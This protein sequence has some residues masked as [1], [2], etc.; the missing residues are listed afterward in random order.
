MSYVGNESSVRGW[1]RLHY[2]KVMVDFLMVD[3]FKECFYQEWANIHKCRNILPDKLSE[4]GALLGAFKFIE[5]TF[6]SSFQTA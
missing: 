4:L 3:W 1:K 5:P 6:K 2:V